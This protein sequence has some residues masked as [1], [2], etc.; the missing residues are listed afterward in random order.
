[1]VGR[2]LMILS[3]DPREISNVTGVVQRSVKFFSSSIC[4][5]A[6]KLK[7]MRYGLV[8]PVSLVWLMGLVGLVGLSCVKIK[9]NPLWY[10]FLSQSM[11]LILV[12]A[13]SQFLWCLFPWAVAPYYTSGVSATWHQHRTRRNLSQMGENSH[14]A[15][16]RHINLFEVTKP[17]FD[18]CSV[19]QNQ[20]QRYFHDSLPYGTGPG[21]DTDLASVMNG[22][23]NRRFDEVPACTFSS[24][25]EYLFTFFSSTSPSPR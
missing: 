24:A 20:C 6:P 22:E 7:N 19:L 23:G 2:I 3:A 9:K 4:G 21:T 18:L 12:R 10:I 11:F 5:G 25:L 13:L 17:A 16:H 1:M 8:D 15:S 14:P